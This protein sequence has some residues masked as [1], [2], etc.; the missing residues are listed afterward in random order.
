MGLIF[1]FEF[2]CFKQLICL[3]II[4][5]NS[6]K[7]KLKPTI[8]DHQLLL[9]IETCFIGGEEGITILITYHVL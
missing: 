6:A 4:S 8:I 9:I 7:P 1:S 3:H 5:Y 2:K